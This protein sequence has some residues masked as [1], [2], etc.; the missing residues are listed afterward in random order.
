MFMFNEII[1]D[2]ITMA[3]R[4]RQGTGPFQFLRLRDQ[5]SIGSLQL[6]GPAS[7]KISKKIP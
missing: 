4:G 5:Q 7:I 3:P 1:I 2:A 6:L